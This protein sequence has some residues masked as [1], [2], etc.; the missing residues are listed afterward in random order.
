ML[1]VYNYCIV[2][3]MQQN[4]ICNKCNNAHTPRQWICSYSRSDPA[5]LHLHLVE[6]I[7]QLV[8]PILQLVELILQL[9]ELL[10]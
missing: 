3:Q 5:E 2:D 9:V 6:L 8:E 1:W 7:L 10:Q 4:C